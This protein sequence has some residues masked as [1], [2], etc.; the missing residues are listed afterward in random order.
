MDNKDTLQSS[1]NYELPLLPL[2]DVVVYPHMV[3][4]LF[5]GREKSI[6]ALDLAMSGDKRILL[7][8][9]KS[10]LTDEPDL[11]DLFSVGT[12]ASILQLLKLP[13]GTVKVLVEGET[14]ITVN[15]IYEDN[16]V[17][18]ARVVDQQ[19][20]RISEREG[21]LLVR[22]VMS[23]FEQYVQLSKK[24]PN[25]VLS[26]LSG[27]K[28]PSKLVDTISA[29]MPMKIEDKQKMLEVE[30]LG[31]RLEYLIGIMQG[32]MDFLQVE[33]KNTWPC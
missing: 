21:E 6:Q 32:E 18:K 30:D 14:R 31:D 19:S 23:Q 4:P 5:V 1:E 20:E 7:L 3:I 27:I 9:Q 13:D 17:I 11:E 15:S 29:H 10:A 26:S 22:S 25:E 8:A 12:V 2:R 28:D 24:V 33:K 16:G